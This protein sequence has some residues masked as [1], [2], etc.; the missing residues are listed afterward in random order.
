MK[1][2]NKIQD[3]FIK[4][5]HIWHFKA[6]FKRFKECYLKGLILSKICLKS[7]RGDYNGKYAK[8]KY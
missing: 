4:Y 3:L 2:V 6:F 7:I 8:F 5:C 1:E